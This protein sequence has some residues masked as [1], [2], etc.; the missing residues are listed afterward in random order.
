MEF[1]NDGSR[2]SLTGLMAPVLF[3][4]SAV[5]LISWARRRNEPLTLIAVE[6]TGL[7]EDQVVSLSRELS[8]ELRGGDLLTRLGIWNLTL[9][10]VG[11]E[12][13]AGHLIFR[14]ENAVKP[15]VGYTAL[16]LGADEDV[17]SG[18]SRLGV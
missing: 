3:Y 15:R 1:S 10:I 4:Q 7:N 8:A 9:M 18:L 17:V 5:R 11:D 6:L 13:A 2:D 14:L 16:S 12:K